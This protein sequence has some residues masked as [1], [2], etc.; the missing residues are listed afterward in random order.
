MRCS[1][2]DAC[3]CQWP[4]LGIAF[5][6]LHCTNHHMR[7]RAGGVTSSGDDEWSI[8]L[9]TGQ[10]ESLLAAYTD[11]LHFIVYRLPLTSHAIAKGI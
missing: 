5:A 4:N 3:E 8:L 6:Y 11:L 10:P 7:S 2:I 1:D 9:Y